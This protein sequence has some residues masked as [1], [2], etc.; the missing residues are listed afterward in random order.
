MAETS[1]SKVNHSAALLAIHMMRMNAAYR[2]AELVRRSKGA[3][4][5]AAKKGSKD[6]AAIALLIG[7]WNAIGAAVRQA[8]PG[9]STSPTGDAFLDAYLNA[10][11]ETVPVCHMYSALK[12]AVEK[13]EKDWGEEFAPDFE[14]LY[15]EYLKWLERNKK[16]KGYKTAHCNGIR[17]FFG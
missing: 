11:F 5:M 15:Q 8:V 17:A 3:K 6:Y 13:I 10:I 12:D 16:S 4:A 7:S 14:W 9:G 2:E 1:D